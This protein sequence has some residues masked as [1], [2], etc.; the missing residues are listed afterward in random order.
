MATSL[1]PSTS[2]LARSSAGA[3]ARGG[4]SGGSGGA[5]GRVERELGHAGV[6]LGGLVEGAREDLALDGAADVGDLFGPLADE[7]D[8]DVGIGVVPRDAVGDVLEELRLPGLRRRHD[9]RALSL[10]EGIHQVDEALAEV[11]A[12]C[13]VV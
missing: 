10:A 2:R 5:L 13:L 9:E 11:R 8:H 3:A 4:V 12:L 7:Y 6:V 1:P